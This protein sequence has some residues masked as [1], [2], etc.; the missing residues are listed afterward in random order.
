MK[1]S[2]R[3]RYGVNAACELARHYGKGPLSIREI[4]TAQHIP[5]PYLEQLLAQL[6]KEGLV[7]SIRGTQGGYELT[8]PPESVT[9]GQVLYAVEGPMA[10]ADCLVDEEATCARVGACAGRRLWDMVYDSIRQVI[11]R[12]TLADLMEEPC[13]CPKTEDKDE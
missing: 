2:T 4:A 12:V 13:A 8:A 3:G 7:R 1:V 11:D 5:R 10:P 9:V 6:R